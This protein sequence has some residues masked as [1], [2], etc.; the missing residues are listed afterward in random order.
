MTDHHRHHCI[1]PAAAAIHRTGRGENVGRRDAG[2]T[3]ALQLGRQHIE[4]HFGIGTGIEMAAVLAHQHLGKFARVR[5]VAVVAETN[6]VR[7]VHVERLRVIR[8]VCAGGGIADVP[9]PDVALEF[10]H[11]L[12]LKHIAHQPRILAHEEFAVLRGHDAG[13]ILAAMLQNRQRVI[14]SLIDRAYAHHSDNS[15][16]QG[17]PPF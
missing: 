8:A 9:D 16:H 13:G 17:P 4:Q 5:Q 12:L 15:T 3:D 2:R 1:A 7:R 10:E 6:A 14:D 11:V